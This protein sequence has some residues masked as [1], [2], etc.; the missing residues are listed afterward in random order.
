MR[1][2]SAVYDPFTITRSLDMEISF[3]L[4]NEAAKDKAVF[5]SNGTC[6]RTS[7]EQALDRKY[8]AAQN[9]ATFEKNGWIL[10]GGN[11]ILPTDSS[12]I[13]LGWWSEAESDES[14]SFGVSESGE[15]ESNTSVLGE[16]V[17]GYMVLGDS[18]DSEARSIPYIAFDFGEAV[19]TYGWALYFDA[20][21]NIYPTEVRIT[22]YGS[23][24]ATVLY[25]SHE[26]NTETAL[27]V[28]AVVEEYY[29]V[30]IEFLAMNEPYRRV[31]LT[32]IDF[33]LTQRFDKDTLVKATL[34]EGADIASRALPSRQ[35]TFV[36]DNSMKIYNMLKPDLLYSYFSSGSVIFAKIVVNGED[37]DM[38]QFYFTSA[39]T[40]SN[41][42]TAE[43]TA[44]DII[45]QLDKMTFTV[46]DN[47]E[48]TL[49]EAVALVLDGVDVQIKYAD[50]IEDMKVMIS[51]AGGY[52]RREMLRLLAQAVMCSCYVDRDGYLNF[53]PLL[54]AEEYVGVIDKNAL[55]NYNGI[56][57]DDPVTKIVLTANDPNVYG[58]IRTYEAGEGGYIVN[59]DNPCV[60]DENGVSVAEW[61]LACYNRRI[62]YKVK[63]RC[64]PAVEIGDTVRLDDVYGENLNAAVTGIDIRWSG[65][66][67]ANTEAVI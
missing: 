39:S 17:L 4:I 38:G 31:R 19:T 15:G 9:W 6:V 12:E 28:S 7:G 22:A 26:F 37:V 44:N 1:E 42:L 56:T 34:V 40:K 8:R 45:A 10:G 41:A 30:K 64:D 33:G 13:Q 25:T 24:G 35:L 47:V 32:E 29:S 65:S 53:K 11:K 14:G 63:N 67:Y 57:V 18:D 27:F 54:T 5:S 52:S 36:F 16:A 48:S 21:N 50:G 2:Q 3:G 51:S 46:S 58:G 20:K 59:V 66:M 23:D 61:L 62:R 60:H 49:S 43:I 55:Y